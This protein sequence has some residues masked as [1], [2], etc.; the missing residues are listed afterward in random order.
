MK[1][2]YAEVS[3]GADN[4]L[5]LDGKPVAIAKPKDALDLG[6]A[7]STGSVFARIFGNENCVDLFGRPIAE[8]DEMVTQDE[9]GFYLFLKQHHFNEFIVR[10]MVRKELY[11]GEERNSFEVLR[12]ESVEKEEVLRKLALTY[13]DRAEQSR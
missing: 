7:D 5:L 2:F 1:R 12:I 4:G 8:V 6:L 11:E 13:A 9:E 10:V 3:V